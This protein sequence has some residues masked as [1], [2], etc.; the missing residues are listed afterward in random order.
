MKVSIITVCKNAQDTIEKTIK[1]VIDQ[2][3]RDIEYIIIDGKSTD[4][5]LD[6]LLKYKDKIDIII[7]EPDEGIYSAM[8]KGIE[9][10]SGD[11]IYFLNSGD[12]LFNTVIIS[13]VVKLFKKRDPDILYGDILLYNKNNPKE[14]TLVKH[15]N[16]D[17]F[18]LARD[19]IYHQAMFV[20][21]NLFKKYGN[22]NI[23][24]KLQADYDW[25]LRVLIKN[26][27]IASRIDKTIAQYLQNGASSNYKKTWKERFQILPLYFSLSEV[28][29]VGIFYWLTYHIV[30]KIKREYFLKGQGN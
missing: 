6:I 4:K 1:S 22:F 10:S 28:I 25:T 20:K 18:Y 9:K 26:K 7:S 30:I 2:D 21:K 23:Q 16:V 19:G 11:I 27:A 12:L 3:Y 14:L 13:S 15:K 24:F 8:N 29:F 5:T 17:R